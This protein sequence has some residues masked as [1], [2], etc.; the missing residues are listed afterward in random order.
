MSN[1]IGAYNLDTNF[2]FGSTAARTIFPSN[3]HAEDLLK[4]GKLKILPEFYR[5]V[6]L[7][8]WRLIN[9]Q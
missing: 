8:Q 3:S 2:L 9:D 6:T 5:M 1:S 7:P 4:Y